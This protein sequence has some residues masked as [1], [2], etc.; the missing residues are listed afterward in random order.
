MSD[1][2]FEF[3]SLSRISNPIAKYR[4]H[5]ISIDSTMHCY[6]LIDVYIN[7][8]INALLWSLVDHQ[9]MLFLYDKE[10]ILILAYCYHEEKPMNFQSLFFPMKRNEKRN[11]RVLREISNVAL[12]CKGG[13]CS[14]CLFTRRGKGGSTA[15]CI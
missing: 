10:D 6:R 4:F 15:L 12:P 14:P 13:S 7:S 11:A 1:L 3:Q 9:L 8:S 2:F 5:T